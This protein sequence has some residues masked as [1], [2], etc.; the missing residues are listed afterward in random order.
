PPRPHGPG[1]RPARMLHAQHGA[2]AD[3]SAAG[4]ARMGARLRPRQQR[5]RRLRGLSA[6]QD[7]RAGRAPA[8]AHRAPRRLRDE[9]G[10]A[11]M[12]RGR[13][14][15]VRTRLT[16]WYSGL[17]LLILALVGSLSYHVLAWSLTQDL[18]AS[19]VT[20]A[21]VLQDSD[22]WSDPSPEEALR[23]LLGPE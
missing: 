1:A 21:Q 19:L 11:V 17:L 8:P 10:G 16:L 18:D 2:G 4:R 6:P 3:A 23:E 20:F 7:R 12:R 15:S 22:R 13:A 9:G 14:L 5:G